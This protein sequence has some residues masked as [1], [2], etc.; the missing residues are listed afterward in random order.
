MTKEITKQIRQEIVSD[1]PNIKIKCRLEEICKE[2]GINLLELSL[3][4]GVRYKTIHD[5]AKNKSVTYAHSY[6]IPIMVALRIKDI[7]E[8]FYIDLGEESEEYEKEHEMY[9]KNGVPDEVMQKMR[10]NAVRQ[11]REKELGKQRLK[12]TG[13]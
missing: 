9:R 4:T 13:E 7:G 1:F 6:L 11:G 10:V 3:L 5:L 2:V 12:S 8:L